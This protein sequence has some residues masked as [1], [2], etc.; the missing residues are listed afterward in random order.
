MSLCSAHESK[1]KQTLEAFGE[2]LGLNHS[3]YDSD[4]EV[5]GSVEF[6]VAGTNYLS[7]IRFEAADIFVI[8]VRGSRDTT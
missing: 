6:L 5:R 7:P 8:Q 3:L 2:P 4:G 1:A